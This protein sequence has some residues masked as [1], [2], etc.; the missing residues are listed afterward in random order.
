MSPTRLVRSLPSRS[1]IRPS[2]RSTRRVLRSI[3][4][5]LSPA[6]PLVRRSILPLHSR[7]TRLSP[8]TRP[9]RRSTLLSPNRATLLSLVILP[10]RRSTLPLLSRATLLSPA[11]RPSRRSILLS[12]SR[13]TRLSL[14]R[15]TRLSLSRA[16]RLSLSRAT[17]LVLRS[18]RRVL[19]TLLSPAI[20]NSRNNT[21]R[22][23]VIPSSRSS[24]LLSRDMLLSTL[25]S[26]DMPLSTLLSH[27]SARSLLLP[28]I[29]PTVDSKSL[30]DID[31][32]FVLVIVSAMKS[33]RSIPLIGSDNRYWTR[34][35]P[36]RPFSL[37]DGSFLSLAFFC[38]FAISLYSIC[39]KG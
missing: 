13:V 20:L 11:T 24:I 22:S 38:V 30:M 2:R 25:L 37:K 12:L 14:S 36:A 39:G 18:T 4:L 23:R 3:R 19:S 27:L 28:R 7:A 26:R 10:S 17:L 16:T 15:A 21:P 8:A 9:S 1:R 35:L 31:D 34:S 33:E 32:L 29:V 5:S 6:T